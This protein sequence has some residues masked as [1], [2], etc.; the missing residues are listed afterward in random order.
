M[1][2]SRHRQCQHTTFRVPPPFR[3][4][5][6][7]ITENNSY[8]T[9]PLTAKLFKF[10]LAKSVITAARIINIANV[11]IGVIYTLL[12][13]YSAIS[14]TTGAVIANPNVPHTSCRPTSPL[15]VDVSRVAIIIAASNSTSAAVGKISAMERITK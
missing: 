15:P 6:R 14:P 12:S 7:Y 4:T 5:Q 13:S 1:S 11:I 9:V 3:R 8:L 10:Y 2:N